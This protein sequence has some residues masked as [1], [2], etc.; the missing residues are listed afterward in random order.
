MEE[1]NQRVCD[2]IATLRN[3]KKQANQNAIFKSIV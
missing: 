1:L 3:N 2:A